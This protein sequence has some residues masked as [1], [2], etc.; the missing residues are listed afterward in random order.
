[1]Y[2]TL[3]IHF[4]KS[5]REIMIKMRHCIIKVSIYQEYIIL[6]A[7]NNMVLILVKQK[8]TIIKTI[9]QNMVSNLT[10]IKN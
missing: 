2:E 3:Q 8:L 7:T 4:N 9:L 5:K 1:M 10:H 6:Y